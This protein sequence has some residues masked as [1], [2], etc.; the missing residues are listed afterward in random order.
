MPNPNPD[1]DTEFN[2]VLRAHGI[3]PPKP[4]E[5]QVSEDD[6]VSMLEASI[7]R[8]TETTLEGKTLD[9]IDELEDDF[10]DAVVASFRAARIREMQEKA[11][12]ERYGELREI[13]ETDF[14]NEVNKAPADTWV[15]L[16]LFQ[17]RY[18]GFFTF[19]LVSCPLGCF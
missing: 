17:S 4:K 14:V 6:I 15:V 19:G 5:L 8:R 11:S 12:K 16:L 3:L 13:S 7:A 2:D 9:E 18:L 1:E 10:D